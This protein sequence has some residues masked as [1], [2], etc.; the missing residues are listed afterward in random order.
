MTMTKF[1]IAASGQTNRHS[2]SGDN[3]VHIEGSSICGTETLCGFVDTFTVWGD[4][5]GPATCPGCLD[6]VRVVRELP[7][8]RRQ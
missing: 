1:R 7:K 4:H 8:F 2:V 3:R 6:V 5:P